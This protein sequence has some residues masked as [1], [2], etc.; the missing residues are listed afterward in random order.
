MKTRLVGLL[1]LK[2]ALSFSMRKAVTEGIFNS[3]LVYCLPLFGGMDVGDLKDLQV[4]QNKAAQIITHSP[5]R[6]HRSTMYDTLQWLTVNQL[7]F[8]HSA[9][10]VFKIRD[11][12]E[13]EHLSEILCQDNRNKRIIIPNLDLKL[14]HKS[15]SMRAAENWNQIPLEIRS[16]PKIGNF[17][18]IAK[19]W[20]LDNVPKFLE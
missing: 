5:P 11:N 3:V 8:Y 19:K 7:I 18:K 12:R 6:A 20:I 14:A 2:F 13:P 10:T 16:Q 17:K 4:V 1:K 15:F 9:I